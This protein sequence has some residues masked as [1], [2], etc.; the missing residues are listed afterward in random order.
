MNIDEY[1]E[2]MKRLIQTSAQ[3]TVVFILDSLSETS[4][5]TTYRFRFKNNN[6]NDVSKINWSK[7]GF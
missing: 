7:E 3:R 1:Y 2:S 6:Q 5:V 4:E